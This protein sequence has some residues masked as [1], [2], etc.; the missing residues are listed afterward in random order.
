MP[1]RLPK[2]I[3]VPALVAGRHLTELDLQIISLVERYR[4]VSISL[5]QS[6]LPGN[7]RVISGRLQYLYHRRLV[8]RFAFR[9][10]GQ[11]QE[12]IYYIDNPATLR[13][14]QEEANHE[15]ADL[16][17]QLGRQ[18]PRGGL[19]RR[20]PGQTM[21]P[22]SLRFLKH[23]IDIGRF[24]ALLDW[25]CHHSNGQV[26]LTDWRRGRAELRSYFYLPKL[27][28]RGLGDEREWG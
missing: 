17:F 4:F 11:L 1:T 5:L 26:Q 22:D 12:N 6:L 25:G 16:H 8:N 14:L 27:T 15:P 21:R 7:N 18:Q 23:E 9:I 2:T 13:L 20:R 28:S 10:L 24:R 3:Q 19:C